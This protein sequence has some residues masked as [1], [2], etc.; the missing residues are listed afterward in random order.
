ML[1]ELLE[2]GDSRA[3]L[4]PQRQDW[5]CG[6]ANALVWA[7]RRARESSHLPR[8]LVVFVNR[9]RPEGRPVRVAPTARWSG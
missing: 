7:P 5:K 3:T 6:E 9:K 2:D 4:D 8:N 1:G